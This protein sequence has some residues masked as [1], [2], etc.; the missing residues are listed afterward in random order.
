MHMIISGFYVVVWEYNETFER[1]NLARNPLKIGWLIP[2]IH[3]CQTIKKKKKKKK[4]RKFVLCLVTSQNQYFASPNPLYFIISHIKEHAFMWCNE[5][6]V[7]KII[8]SIFYIVVIGIF[9]ATVSR[10]P[11]EKWLVSSRGASSR[12]FCKT[13]DNK[14]KFSF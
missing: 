1:P 12:R 14:W 4:N 5:S 10:K 6:K 7:V 2:K 9:N 13:I 8:F 11:N 3:F